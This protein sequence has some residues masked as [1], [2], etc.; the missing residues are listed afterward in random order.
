M[1]VKTPRPAQ[2]AGENVGPDSGP[3]LPVSLYNIDHPMV[4]RVPVASFVAPEE[5]IFCPGWAVFIGIPVLALDKSV[6]SIPSVGDVDSIVP[7]AKH[8]LA[9]RVLRR[10]QWPRRRI[11]GVRAIED[12]LKRRP[13]SS[14]IIG[15]RHRD[16]VR[17]FEAF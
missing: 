9:C 8:D 12:H 7:S 3:F 17:P 15:T 11:S 2:F 4:E 6:L 14:D 13:R 5:R 1:K 10:P 16:V